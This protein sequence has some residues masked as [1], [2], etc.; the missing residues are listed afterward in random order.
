MTDALAIDLNYD[1][2]YTWKAIW[3]NNN[4]IISV[5]FE[6][7]YLIVLPRQTTYLSDVENVNV[8]RFQY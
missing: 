8:R 3:T 4:Q 5:Y 6:P 1:N 2:W 7:F